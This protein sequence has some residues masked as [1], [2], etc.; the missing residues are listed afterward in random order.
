MEED[1]KPYIVGIA[2]GSAS[3]KTSFIRDLSRMIPEGSLAVV[4][5]DNY[6]FEKHLQKKDPRGEI[7][8]DLPEAIDDQ[9]FH[10]D[11]Q[12][13]LNGEPVVRKEYTYNNPGADARLIS[14]HPAPILL[15]EGLF[16]FHFRE[17]SEMMNLKVYIDALEE[18]K[19]QRRILRDREERGY[20]ESDVRYRWENHVMPSYLSFLKPHRDHCDVVITNNTSYSRGLEVMANHL[21]AVLA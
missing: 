19:L 10:R 21:M 3:G 17:I 14:I 9:A 13:L 20:P 4:S 16:V 18:I 2:G 15:V 8:F 6:Y 7:N 5:Q 12:S 1:R 11:I